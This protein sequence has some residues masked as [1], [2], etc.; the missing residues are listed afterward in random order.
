MTG[1]AFTLCHRFV[2]T[3]HALF[4]LPVIV[5]IEADLRRRL[6]QHAA[7][8]AGM[9]GMAGLAIPFLNRFVLRCTGHIIVTVQ[10]EFTCGRVQTDFTPSELM[11]VITVTA[12]YRRVDHFFQQSR[13]RRAVLCMALDATGRDRVVLMR[14]KEV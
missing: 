3:A 7:I 14:G 12:A 6:S 2:R 5:T 13:V 9:L 8:L 4:F 10:A 11:T 1:Q